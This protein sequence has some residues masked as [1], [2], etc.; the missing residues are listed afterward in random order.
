ML[1]G[2]EVAV[3]PEI[4]RKQINMVWAECQFLGFKPV[5][6]RKMQALKG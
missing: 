5:G 4:N 2:A 3:F 1:Y 6:A